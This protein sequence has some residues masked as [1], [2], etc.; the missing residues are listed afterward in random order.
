MLPGSSL[1]ADRAGLYRLTDVGESSSVP[2]Q[3][4]ISVIME[5]MKGGID[6]ISFLT[7]SDPPLL[8]TA[9]ICD[10]DIVSFLMESYTHENWES[11]NDFFLEVMDSLLQ[12]E[13]RAVKPAI[14]MLPDFNEHFLGEIVKIFV[15]AGL[16]IGLGGEY[17]IGGLFLPSGTSENDFLFEDI[18][19]GGHEESV[20]RKLAETLPRLH[21]SPI[22][23]AAVRGK[24]DFI[25]HMLDTL[26]R[27]FRG[28][29][30][31][32]DSVG[33]VPLHWACD[34]GC[35]WVSDRDSWTDEWQDEDWQSVNPNMPDGYI[36]GGVIGLVQASPDLVSLIDPVT[37]LYPYQLVCA[38]ETTD[39]DSSYRL[40]RACPTA[41]T[42]TS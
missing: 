25:K 6:V 32:R 29:V 28:C 34:S 24:S 31:L 39:L 5:G 22:L 15:D 27:I 33:R 19:F 13:P 9:D 36:R 37:G 1:I 14:K 10:I 42:N 30:V 3:P 23:H 16:R 2:S 4:V 35:E 21:E 8:T 40:L 7:K 17:G 38:G 12:L 26:I 41:L 11:T 20:L 18:D